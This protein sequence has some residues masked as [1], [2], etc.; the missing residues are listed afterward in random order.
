[1]RQLFLAVFCGLMFLSQ[2]VVIAAPGSQPRVTG[3]Q[4]QQTLQQ[5]RNA[6]R[7]RILGQ[8][9]KHCTLIYARLR[10]MQSKPCIGG[11]R[12]DPKTRMCLPRRNQYMP[13][14]RW[15]PAAGRC[16]PRDKFDVIA[17]A[18]SKGRYRPGKHHAQ[19]PSQ[20]ARMYS[21][22][23]KRLTRAAHHCRAKLQNMRKEATRKTAREQRAC[24]I[25][26]RKGRE[27]I[28]RLFCK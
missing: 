12:L 25:A 6:T 16:R 24:L 19:L 8:Q 1:M 13:Y 7:A 14:S 26:K 21:T 20:S 15:D 11:D 3:A 9:T 23:L 10:K 28:A 2:G 22:A 18:G 4:Q 27:D 17:C 5:K